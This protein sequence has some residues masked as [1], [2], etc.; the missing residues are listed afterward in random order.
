[1]KRWSIITND[2]GEHIVES[3]DT[4]A[5]EAYHLELFSDP[6]GRRRL[7]AIY[8]DKADAD[9]EAEQHRDRDDAA[10]SRRRG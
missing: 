5:T 4:E 7:V 2:A 1:M 8:S 3:V 6:T 9:R 10:E